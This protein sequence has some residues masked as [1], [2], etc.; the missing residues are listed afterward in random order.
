MSEQ[1]EQVT[2]EP[3]AIAP[4]S[5]MPEEIREK[6]DAVVQWVFNDMQ[7]A[8]AAEAEKLGVSEYELPGGTAQFWGVVNRGDL[9]ELR[10]HVTLTIADSGLTDAQPEELTSA[11]RATT[12]AL[13]GAEQ[14][15]CPCPNC[16]AKRAAASGQVH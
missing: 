2:V 14:G 4:S 6:L 10:T 16:E 1:D 5:E 7:R 12:D 13:L 11:A 9:P 15:E 3:P 8:A